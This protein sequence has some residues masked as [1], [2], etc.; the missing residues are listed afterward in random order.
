[1]LMG[2]QGVARLLREG[3][4]LKEIPASRKKRAVILRWLANQFEPEIK[5]KEAQVKEIIQRHHPDAS[6]LRRELIA[7]KLMSRE[8]GLYWRV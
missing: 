7:E 4:R 8:G 1:M 6:Y 3:T 2:T 5:Y